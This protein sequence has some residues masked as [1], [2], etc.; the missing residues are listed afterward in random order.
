MAPD[1]ALGWLNLC[2]RNELCD[3]MWENLWEYACCLE[4]DK[5]ESAIEVWLKKKKLQ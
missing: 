1:L 2:Q 5:R 3:Y 4:S